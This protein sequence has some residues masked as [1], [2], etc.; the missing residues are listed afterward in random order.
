M[1]DVGE[2]AFPHQAHL[3]HE[4]VVPAAHLAGVEEPG[5]D[6]QQ[7]SHQDEPHDETVAF[8]Q[9]LLVALVGQFLGL[10]FHVELAHRLLQVVLIDRVFQQRVASQMKG[11]LPGVAVLQSLVESYLRP[12]LVVLVLELRESLGS[13]G[14]VV[15]RLSVD[16]L[17]AEQ[18]PHLVLAH[19]ERGVVA[20]FG[21]QG[22]GLPHVCLRVGVASHTL[23]GR[24]H[25]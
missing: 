18:L 10:V 25:L 7:Q 2:E 21:K 14:E 20:R 5:D 4:P 13:L 24:C 17:V 16:T 6:Q 22:H 19:G 1:G 3:F 8:L 9:S 23:L 15:G 11:R 12:A